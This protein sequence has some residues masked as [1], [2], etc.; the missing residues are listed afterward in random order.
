ML[1]LPGWWA[2]LAV[3]TERARQRSSSQSLLANLVGHYHRCLPAPLAPL[4]QGPPAAASAC[5][6]LLGAAC[7]CFRLPPGRR[8]PAGACARPGDP[9]APELVARV[10]ALRP[11]A[12]Q[13]RRA[14]Q[15]QPEGGGRIRHAGRATAPARLSPC[16]LPGRAAAGATAA[17]I[18][19]AAAAC[20]PACCTLT[21][22]PPPAPSRPRPLPPPPRLPPP[23]LAAAAPPAIPAPSPPPHRPRRASARPCGPSHTSQSPCARALRWAV[24]AVSQALN[25]PRCGVPENEMTHN[26]RAGPGI[27]VRTETVDSCEA[28]AA[29]SRKHRRVGAEQPLERCGETESQRSGGVL[30]VW[31]ITY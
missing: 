5:C 9:N 21:L 28:R 11:A 2:V 20:L 3:G 17:A 19:R 10:P 6:C 12:A 18:R 31:T 4:Q 25:Q 27:G 13:Q 29:H 8:R 7:C 30:G 26:T 23:P 16:V 24:V 15:Q 14:Q 22:Q 1:T